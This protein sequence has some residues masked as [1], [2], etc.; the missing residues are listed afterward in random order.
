MGLQEGCLWGADAGK[1]E[2]DTA[3]DAASGVDATLD[4]GDGSNITHDAMAACK[5]TLPI[6]VAE[7]KATG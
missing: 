5:K 3:T 2:V 6:M 7:T 1:A 4:V